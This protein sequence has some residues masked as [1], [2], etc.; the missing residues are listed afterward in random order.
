MSERGARKRAALFN[1]ME[2]NMDINLEMFC[3][4]AREGIE[5]PFLFGEFTYATNG[6]ILVRIPKRDGV[7]KKTQKRRTSSLRSFLKPHVHRNHA[8]TRYRSLISLSPSNGKKSRSVPAVMAPAKITAAPLASANALCV[9]GQ[10]QSATLG[11]ARSASEAHTTA[12]NTSP[13]CDRCRVWKLGH[14]AE[15]PRCGFAL[16]AAR[17]C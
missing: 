10:E 3:D 2:A 12:P 1:Q 4:P 5:R 14:R 9:T 17:G 13:G 11:G 15:Q 16:T 8:T 6:H 7:A